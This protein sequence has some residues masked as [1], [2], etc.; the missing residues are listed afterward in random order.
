MWV[1]KIHLVNPQAPSSF[2][3]RALLGA[4]DEE[5][6]R[7]H[8]RFYPKNA[9]FQLLEVE[10]A[11]GPLNLTDRGTQIES[12]VFKPMDWSGLT[13]GITLV[14]VRSK[15]EFVKSHAKGALNVEYIK[16]SAGDVRF[17]Q[18]FEYFAEVD[19]FHTDRLPRNK[20]T[21]L[22]FIGTSLVDIR[23]FRALV[24]AHVEGWK[25]LYWLRSGEMGRLHI[26]PETPASTLDLSTLRSVEDLIQFESKTR[27]KLISTEMDTIYSNARPIFESINIPINDISVGFPIEKLP[28]DKEAP[29]VFFGTD[30]YDQNALRAARWIK[31]A[32]WK[33]V[34]WYRGGRMDWD[35]H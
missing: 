27:A 30:F 11:R 1:K 33:N 28:K 7:R 2:G 25:N 17:Y 29:L 22:V 10:Y 24:M 21:P 34:Y 18:M 35:S 31:E 6:F 32:G 9:P 12:P 8:I 4:A 5:D 26:D 3:T 20:D 16:N 15:S 19:Q 23:P 13:Q 14:D